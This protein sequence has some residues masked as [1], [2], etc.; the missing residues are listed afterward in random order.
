MTP[1]ELQNYEFTTQKFGGYNKQQVDDFVALA[2]KEFEAYYRENLE[3][4]DRITVLNES[5]K[6]F[7]KM[8]ESLQNTLLFAQNTADDITKNAKQ[9]AETILEEARVTAS[10][11]IDDANK[12]KTDADSKTK[13]IENH[14]K[15]FK[16]KYESLLQAELQLLG[17]FDE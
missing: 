16:A 17:D 1:I 13:E 9:K 6:T 4:K 14:Y 11:I 5:L 8:E 7:K 12:K 15:M 10:G 2:L 3:L